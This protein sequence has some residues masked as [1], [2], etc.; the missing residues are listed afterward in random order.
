MKTF[1]CDSCGQEMKLEKSF[2]AKPR[3]HK[4][5]KYRVRRFRCDLCD[6]SK[7]VFADGSI[8]EKGGLKAPALQI[9]CSLCGIFFDHKH[10]LLEHFE[11]SHSLDDF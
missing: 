4:K 9:Q 10:E 6:I 3:G 1:N 7:T 11:I 5:L 8:D 2:G